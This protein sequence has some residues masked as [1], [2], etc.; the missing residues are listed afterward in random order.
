MAFVIHLFPKAV[1][2]RVGWG[3]NPNILMHRRMET[4]GFAP[5]PTA[6]KAVAVRS[7][8]A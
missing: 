3:A 7:E 8:L 4:L 5:Q 2:M 6:A 1:Q